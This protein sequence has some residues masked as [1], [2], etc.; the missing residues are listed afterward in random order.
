M[1]GRIPTTDAEA[2]RQRQRRYRARLAALRLPEADD[3]DR[4]MI[5]ELRAFAYD[6]AR[7]LDSDRDGR[8]KSILIGT[9]SRLAA[10]GYDH[11]RCKKLVVRRL[12]TPPPDAKKAFLEGG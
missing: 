9:L 10:D 1:A 4:A 11:G 6:V 8:L 7:G 2:H 3:I 5:C 12:G